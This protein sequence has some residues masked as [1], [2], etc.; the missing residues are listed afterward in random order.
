MVA[1]E[2]MESLSLSLFLPQIS[3]LFGRIT[4]LINY[5]GKCKKIILSNVWCWK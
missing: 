5:K 1:A 3:L 4:F 2:K